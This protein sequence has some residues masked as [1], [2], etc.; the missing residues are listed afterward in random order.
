MT[1]HLYPS[2]LVSACLLAGGVSA[3]V[4][5]D[6]LAGTQWRSRV[7][8]V[9]ASRP[10]DPKLGQQ[11]AIFRAMGQE[12]RERDLKLVE[13][14][15]DTPQATVLRRRFDLP[16]G[17]FKALLLG[18]DGGDKLTSDEPLDAEA[19][20]PTIDAMPMRQ[21]EVRRRSRG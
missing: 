7:V 16:P 3:G 4:A 10:D 11:R 17:G 9:L 13:V 2:L 8:L 20:L 5:A 14:V 12:A 18:K 19:L 6:P 21:D 1:L 15:G